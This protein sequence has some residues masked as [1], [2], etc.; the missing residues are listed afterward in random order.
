ML[1]G[2]AIFMMVAFHFCY[3]LEFF[4]L[5]NLNIKSDALWINLRNFIVSLFLFIAGASLFIASKKRPDFKTH[6]RKQKWLAICAVAVS[7]AT[8]PIFPHSWIYFGVLHFILV[9][10]LLSYFVVSKCL[11]CFF[12]GV[13]ILILGWTFEH[14]AF[15]PKWINWIGLATHKPFTED[16][17]PLIPWH[18]VFLLGSFS[19]CLLL[20]N[21]SSEKFLCKSYLTKTAKL[22]T[23]AGR[24]SLLI[25]I[26]HQPLLMAFM[27]PLSRLSL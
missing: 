26:L 6:L 22:L 10:R 8:Y 17:V 9:A 24:H 15:N 20:R 11:L 13:L 5:A 25:Y 2:S 3:N 21:P 1:R 27:F 14:E 16:Y 4:Q 23:L 7:A 12:L 19:M 18:G